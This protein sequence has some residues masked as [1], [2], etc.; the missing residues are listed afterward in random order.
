MRT[1]RKSVAVEFKQTGD[2][3][4]VFATKREASGELIID[5][6]GDVYAD[7]VVGVQSVDI[8]CINHVGCES[9]AG[10]GETFETERDIRARGRLDLSTDHGRYQY[11]IWKALGD[12]AEFSYIF[13]IVEADHIEVRGQ[14][15]RR[16]KQLVVYSIDLVQSPA[17]IDTRIVDL[18]RKC[19]CGCG[20]PWS[21]CPNDTL[22]TARKALGQ[23]EVALA[24]E[25]SVQLDADLH[26]KMHPGS[27]DS[28]SWAE[29]PVKSWNSSTLAG[30]TQGLSLA[31]LRYGRD[32]P[33]P[34]F[35]RPARER[36]APAF[37]SGNSLNGAAI[38]QAIWVR[39]GLS[40]EQAKRTT[41]H[42]CSHLMFPDESEY[43]VSW[44][45]R[46]AF[47]EFASGT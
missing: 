24:I 12:R 8:G 44:R 26:S 2:F 29:V 15:V 42:E 40:A 18:K 10:K 16:L 6:D 17:G 27:G 31:K 38:G 35:F 28:F 39:D 23:N 47:K 4:V 7:G 36:E 5:H 1:E 32:F 45:E 13:S 11:D 30:V 22:S 43:Q 25:R 46:E 20:K 3:E 19:S 21:E 37:K 34:R 33:T 9:P 14:R 41:F